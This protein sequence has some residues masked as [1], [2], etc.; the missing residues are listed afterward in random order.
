MAITDFK[1]RHQQGGEDNHNH[2]SILASYAGLILTVALCTLFLIKN[3]VLEPF[4]PRLYRHHHACLSEISK[5]SFLNQHVAVGMRLIILS[6]GGYPFFATVFGSAVLSS[7]VAPG[8][9]VTMGD[10]L[11]VSSQLLVAMYI[12]ELIYRAKISVVS[13]LHHLGTVLVAQSSVAISVYGHKDARYEFLLCC[14]W[15]AFDVLVEFLPS[16]AIIRYRTALTSHHH[17]HF[18]FKFTMIWTFIGTLL[19]SVIAMYLFGILWDQWELSFKIA[20]PLLH[21]AFSAAQLHGT[22]IFRKMMIREKQKIRE[23]AKRESEEDLKAKS[24]CA[25]DDGSG[26]EIVSVV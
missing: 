17:L 14:V 6:L 21:I 4:L 18:I 26:F 25:T 2:I 20:T 3:Y 5:R 24:D 8:G 16:L 22:N 13:G 11:I 23:E 15:G 19:E 12:F 9:K 1:D 7:P 10:C